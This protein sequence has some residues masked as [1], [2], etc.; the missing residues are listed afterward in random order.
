[1]IVG[2]ATNGRACSSWMIT[3]VRG[4]TTQS[5]LIGPEFR[6]PG[7][8]VAHRKAPIV[9]HSVENTTRSAAGYATPAILRGYWRGARSSDRRAPPAA[10][11]DTR[12][13]RRASRTAVPHQHCQQIVPTRYPSPVHQS[14]V[15]AT[16]AAARPTRFQPTPA[17]CPDRDTS[18]MISRRPAPS[19]TRTP[20]SCARCVNGIRD[21]AVRARSRRG[22]RRARQRRRAGRSRAGFHD[23]SRD[24]IL[25]HRDTL[26]RHR[27]D[28]SRAA[29]ARTIRP[30]RWNSP[31]ARTIQHQPRPRQGRRCSDP[32]KSRRVT[33]RRRPT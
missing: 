8:S 14:P 18:R 11:A 26:N 10:R 16:P 25:E 20:S 23:R 29:P 21:Q 4:K 28:R 27:S 1:M 3:A 24:D 30:A 9:T 5:S 22:R 31:C 32:Q 12:N 6:N 33:A 17:A 2:S 19:A 15:V 7:W 13:Q